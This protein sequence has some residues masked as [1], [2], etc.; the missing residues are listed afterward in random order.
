LKRF[1]QLDEEFDSLRRPSDAIPVTIM[2]FHGESTFCRFLHGRRIAPRGA[3]ITSFGFKVFVG[4]G[5]FLHA[6]GDD[7]HGL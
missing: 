1:C 3:A 6:H 4:D 5:L 7:D 2:D